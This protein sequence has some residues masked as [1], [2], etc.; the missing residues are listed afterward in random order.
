M[1]TSGIIGDSSVPNKLA[2]AASQVAEK[3]L[4][5]GCEGQVTSIDAAVALSVAGSTTSAIE[6][7]SL[8]R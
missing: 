2:W 7:V 1:H 4:T 8:N 6:A 3:L 5:L